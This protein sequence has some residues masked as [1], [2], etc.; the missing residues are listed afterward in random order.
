[1]SKNRNNKPMELTVYLHLECQTKCGCY[2]VVSLLSSFF[3]YFSRFMCINTIV[4]YV[5]ALNYIN[6][7]IWWWPIT[8]H[9]TNHTQS[10]KDYCESG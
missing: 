8:P 7:I 9:R 6:A 2:F 5:Q 4:S 10:N 3:W 1:M